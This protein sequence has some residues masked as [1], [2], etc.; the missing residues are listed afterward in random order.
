MLVN[1]LDLRISRGVNSWEPWILDPDNP[2]AAATTGDNSRDNVEQVE[3]RG[4]DACSYNIEIGHKGS[5]LDGAAQNYSLII[6]VEPP[7]PKGT[8]L[9]DEDFSGGLPAGWSVETIQ[10]VS[11][12]IN[13]PVTND[14]R[15]DN[16]TGG[17][18][19]F[20]MVDNNTAVTETLLRTATVDLS[21]FDAAV[22]RFSSYFFFDELETISVDVSTDGGANW[23]EGWRNPDGFIHDPYRIVTDLSAFIAGHPDVRLQFH[24]NSNGVPQGNLWQ[25]DDI[26]LEVFEVQTAPENLPEPA[27]SPIPVDGASGVGSGASIEWTSGAQTDSHDVFFGTGIPLGPEAFQ[28]NQAGTVYDP[29]L[30]AA[31]TTYYW[32]VD[33]IN[34]EGS[35]RG[36]T[37]SFTTLGELPELILSDGFEAD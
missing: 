3:I 23:I 1:D 35:V 27:S 11:W 5:L 29:G 6:S 20:V 9:I 32:R 26:E 2:A 13:T 31:D 33:E 22:L 25:L 34:A 19:N 18:G 24:F 21:G 7:Q 4:A 30:L 15:L 37:W 36:C 12:T 10:G 28:G 17:S 14:L 16:H 8:F